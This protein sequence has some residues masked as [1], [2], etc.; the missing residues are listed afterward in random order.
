MNI[1]KIHCVPFGTL[2]LIK[3]Q[4]GKAIYLFQAAFNILKLTN[5]HIL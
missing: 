2:D 3:P 4:T 5:W 1:K